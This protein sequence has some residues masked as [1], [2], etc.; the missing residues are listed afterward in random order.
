M[1]YGR[2]QEEKKIRTALRNLLVGLGWWVEI[3]HGNR[4]QH[5]WPDLYI[6]HPVHGNRWIDTKVEG[7]YDYTK[8]QR[9]KWPVWHQ[10]GTGIWILTDATHE[11][12]ERLFQP[13]NWLDY[14][15]SSYG[16]PWDQE[17]DLDKLLDELEE[18]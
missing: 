9:Q 12:Y 7:K 8:A 4:F 13:P 16:D 14:W 17:L 18:D 3:S 15:K 1:A 6:T 11:Q 2:K 5:G 10:H